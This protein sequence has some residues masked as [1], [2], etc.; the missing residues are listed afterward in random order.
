MYNNNIYT[1]I[2]IHTYIHKLYC[3]KLNKCITF[4]QIEFSELSIYIIYVAIHGMGRFCAYIYIIFIKLYRTYYYYISIIILSRINL[5][6]VH[7]LRI[8]VRC[9]EYVLYKYNKTCIIQ[10]GS[11]Q[12]DLNKRVGFSVNVSMLIAWVGVHMKATSK[13]I[14]WCPSFLGLSASCS[15][16]FHLTNLSLQL[17]LQLNPMCLPWL[18]WTGRGGESL[19]PVLLRLPASCLLCFISTSMQLGLVVSQAEAS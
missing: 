1:Y 15:L 7:K 19:P 5:N 6:N 10:N 4:L 18:L 14:H 2:Y 8:Y 16:P 13:T 9:R 12:C 17:L 3:Y 11:R